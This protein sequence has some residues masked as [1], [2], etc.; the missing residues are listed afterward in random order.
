MKILTNIVARILF[1][2]PL[3]LFAMGHLTNANS[4]AEMMLP[5]FPGAIFFVYL[6]GLALLAAA[7]SILIKKK[8]SLATLLLALLL[9]MIAF[10]VYFPSMIGTDPVAAEMAMPHF[11]KDLGL[12]GA[13][14]FMS[15]VFSKE[16]N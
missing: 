13:S 12:A 7:I 9:I 15:G 3:V 14:L 16:E 4:M 8:A 2:L 1:V 10:I 11:L 5:N 6:T